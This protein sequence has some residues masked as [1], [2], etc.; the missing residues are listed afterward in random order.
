M[1]VYI[2]RRILLFIPTLIVISLLAFAIS[3]ASPGDPVDRLVNMRGDDGMSSQHGTNAALK[4]RKRKELGLHL[5]LFYFTV[6]TMA[7]PDTLRRIGDK[8]E[9]NAMKILAQKH[10]NWENV[11]NYYKTIKKNAVSSDARENPVI[12]AELEE[13]TKTHSKIE[14]EKSLNAIESH[15]DIKEIRAAYNKMQQNSTL[16]KKYV[17]AIDWNG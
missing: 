5:P 4:D 11:A 13:L 16:W 7:V 10:G 9:R 6:R 1:T 14:I 17:P 2:I 3:A 8:E 12:F 15:I